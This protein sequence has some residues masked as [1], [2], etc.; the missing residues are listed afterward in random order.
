MFGKSRC[1][2]PLCILQAKM[3]HSR[4]TRF[5]SAL[6][7]LAATPGLSGSSPAEAPAPVA[8]VNE[9][10]VAFARSNLGK[11]VGNG[12]CTTLAVAALR[13]SGA[14][15][16]SLRRAD[17]DYV[18][19]EL[20]E[21]PKEARPG[22]I[23]Q[24]RDAVF[25]GKQRFSGGRWISWHYEYH[26]HTAI[27]DTVKMDGKILIVLHQNVGGK[28]VSEEKKRTVQEGTLR[29][30]SLQK[31]GWVRIYRPL[32]PIEAEPADADEASDGPDRP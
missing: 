6:L 1:A 4:P 9:K 2:A 8:T 11:K 13:D 21:S 31:G 7:I 5:L 28:D 18:W 14:R 19:G 22:D 3:N 27:V 17:G 20:I 10:I 29:M 16:F 15:V 25:K 12:D 23:L 30:D 32:P 24:F 26:H